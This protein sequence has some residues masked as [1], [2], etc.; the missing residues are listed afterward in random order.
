MLHQHSLLR[1][2]PLHRFSWW[3]VIFSAVCTF[4]LAILQQGCG[5]LF[6][7]LH[8]IRYISYTYW[9]T[10]YRHILHTLTGTH[11]VCTYVRTYPTTHT[12]PHTTHFLVP[13]ST[14]HHTIPHTTQCLAPH[15]TPHHTHHLAPHTPSHHTH[16]P[17]TTHPPPPLTQLCSSPS[18]PLSA[19]TSGSG[20]VLR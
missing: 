16:T 18:S 9:S 10:H 14:S 4:L 3:C 12:L 7:A 19:P 17:Q 13:H 2:F 1:N 20:A 15:T 11:Y 6:A 5:H 8:R